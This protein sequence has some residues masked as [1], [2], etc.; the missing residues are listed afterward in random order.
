MAVIDIVI[1]PQHAT[2]VF[3]DCRDCAADPADAAR[4]EQIIGH[5]VAL[6]QED[7]DARLPVQEGSGTA[8]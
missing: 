5:A 1:T 4:I 7:A 2:R 6:D 8:G 3:F